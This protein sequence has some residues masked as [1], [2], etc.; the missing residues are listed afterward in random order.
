ML[1]VSWGKAWFRGGPNIHGCEHI[2][3]VLRGETSGGGQA[4]K[5]ETRGRIE[6]RRH[7]GG[8]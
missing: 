4:I 6:A 8:Q 7:D 5:V 1:R 2:A 3:E